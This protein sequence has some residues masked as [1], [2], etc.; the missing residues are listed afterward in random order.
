MSLHSQSFYCLQYNW[1]RVQQSRSS[2]GAGCLLGG[3]KFVL[4]E[5]KKKKS[6]SDT[7]HV[8][9]DSGKKAS[10]QWQLRRKGDSGCITR[11]K[12]I[13]RWGKCVCEGVTEKS[14]ETELLL[15]LVFPSHLYFTFFIN[16]NLHS[17][18]STQCRQS[19]SSAGSK[20][21]FVAACFFNRLVTQEHIS[22]ILFFFSRCW[23]SFSSFKFPRCMLQFAKRYHSSV[24]FFLL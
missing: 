8:P 22:F 6:F 12:L 18:L 7:W 14:F 2:A 15:S 11:K 23:T 3:L 16:L 24:P 4:I 17:A 5:S 9:S 1:N 10:D 20:F 13:T 19:W 21:I